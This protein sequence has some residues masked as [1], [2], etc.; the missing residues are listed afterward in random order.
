MLLPLF[1]FPCCQMERE[2]Q[3]L[4]GRR[5]LNCISTPPYP[6]ATFQ[7]SQWSKQSPLFGVDRPILVTSSLFETG[8]R[9]ISRIEITHK[10]H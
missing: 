9:V 10:Q 2:R 3:I 6:A 4:G 7:H 8:W 1:I 5:K